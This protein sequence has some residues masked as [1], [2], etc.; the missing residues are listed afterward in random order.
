[1][2]NYIIALLFL[3]TGFI[4]KKYEQSDFA[5]VGD[6]RQLTWQ[7]VRALSDNGW[8]I[9]SH[10]YTHPCLTH[11][12]PNSLANEVSISKNLIEQNLGKPVYAFAFPYGH[13]NQTVIESLRA[14]GYTSAYTVRFGKLLPSG[15][16][17]QIPRITITNS[18]TL[19]SFRTKVNGY[20]ATYLNIRAKI[21]DLVFA[22]PEIREIAEKWM[23]KMNSRNVDR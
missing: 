22:Y 5:Y 15:R 4:G 18:D 2:S 3:S 23:Y 8:D 14:S 12:N 20:A 13:Y 10:G 6:D 7:E 21:K 16:N 11:L 19:S 1:V 9:Q 17:F